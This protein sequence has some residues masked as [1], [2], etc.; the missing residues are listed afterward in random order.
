MFY[1]SINKE[2]FE[3][4]DNKV[5]LFLGVKGW[6]WPVAGCWPVPRFK[7]LLSHLSQ[8]ISLHTRRLHCTRPWSLD[9]AEL[10]EKIWQPWLKQSRQLVDLKLSQCCTKSDRAVAIIWDCTATGSDKGHSLKRLSS[11]NF[12]FML[13]MF[14]AQV[15]GLTLM[16]RGPAASNQ[17][18]FISGPVLS[19]V[20][21]WHPKL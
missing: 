5:W 4:L 21:R 6:I 14:E 19:S 3:G 10:R 16:F 1:G 7:L 8:R 12:L 17:W 9:C 20:R 2:T 15:A 18:L 13:A 11:M